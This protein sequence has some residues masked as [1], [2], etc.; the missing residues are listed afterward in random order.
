M[1][2]YK[3]NHEI[4][5]KRKKSTGEE[6]TPDALVCQMLG[7]LPK[8]VWTENK[9]FLDPAVGNGQFLVFILLRKLVAGHDPLKA[10][11][12]LYGA[13]IMRDNVQECQ[14][15]LLKILAGYVK[16]IPDHVRSVF[17]NIVW[18]NPKKYKGGSLGYDFEFNHD[19][20]A[21]NVE[22]WMK[23]INKTNV[24]ENVMVP[25]KCPDVS[26]YLQGI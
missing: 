5:E 16:I 8:E 14:L 11:Q 18:V 21:K 10:L 17:Q 19:V 22:R 24:F 9:T 3:K 1:S 6:F 26:P 4:R 23:W 25:E 12:S 7:K 2:H 15:R 13:D 20:K